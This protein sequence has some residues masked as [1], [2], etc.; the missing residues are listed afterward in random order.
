[1]NGKSNKRKKGEKTTNES[2]ELATLSIQHNFTSVFNL[3]TKNQ[4][5]YFYINHFQ[6]EAHCQSVAEASTRIRTLV[7]GAA[8]LISYIREAACSSRMLYGKCVALCLIY[9]FSRM[10]IYIS[11]FSTS[12]SYS[13]CQPRS[14]DT[15]KFQQISR[16]YSPPP[17]IAV[18]D[19]IA[20]VLVQ[21][22]DSLND[23]V[24]KLFTE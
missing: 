10:L 3:A 17:S 19:K 23:L 9:A 15:S 4:C 22:Q 18:F 5:L 24:E 12:Y 13:I 20:V 2:P 11:I 1:M 21:F 14:L 7:R 8:Q 16:V 6:P